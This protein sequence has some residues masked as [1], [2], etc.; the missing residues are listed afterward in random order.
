[1]PTL[2]TF[3]WPNL[4]TNLSKYASRRAPFQQAHGEG[5]PRAAHST[6]SLTPRMERV[7]SPC[8]QGLR[9]PAAFVLWCSFPC[10]ASCRVN[11][12][13]PSFDQGD[14]VAAYSH[15][16]PLH[17]PWKEEEE[18]RKHPKYGQALGSL[19]S[20]TKCMLLGP[21]AFLTMMLSPNGIVADTH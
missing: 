6:L 5:R 11:L 10:R 4:E 12:G 8:P 9:V 15:D 17:F 19:K 18:G 7:L 14:G 20:V 3:I 21:W 1:M 13:D 16:L 2:Q